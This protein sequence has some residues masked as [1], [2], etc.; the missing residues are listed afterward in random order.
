MVST[1][2]PYERY[3]I[4]S[5]API[6]RAVRSQLHWWSLFGWRGYRVLKRGCF[7]AEWAHENQL[8]KD[9]VTPFL[10]HPLGVAWIIVD[11]LKLARRWFLLFLAILHDSLE[12]SDKLHPTP[13]KRRWRFDFYVHTFG[14]RMAKSLLLLSRGPK[15][16]KEDYVRDFHRWNCVR[17]LVFRLWWAGGWAV[18]LVK[19]C[20]RL[21]NLRT[22][23]AVPRDKQLKKVAETERLYLPLVAVLRRRL[24]RKIKW[25]ADYLG[26]QLAGM[27]DMIKRSDNWAATAPIIKR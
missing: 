18:V 13:N 4:Q 23:D 12:E 22:L 8:R 21:N 19:L 5:A 2:V 3:P 27:C 17:F 20:D 1:V 7:I 10:E 16:S 11:E 14:V 25:V 6:L 15:Q 24:P 9:D 26:E